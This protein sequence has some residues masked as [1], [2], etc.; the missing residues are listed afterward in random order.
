M[1]DKKGENWNEK[2]LK[3]LIINYPVFGSDYC[4]KSLN[5][6]SISIQKKAQKLGLTYIG[7]NTKYSYDN[8]CLIVKESINFSDVV[9]K[10]NL[11]TGRGN[12]KTVKKY[13]E[14]H[15]IDI[16]HFKFY[17]SHNIGE[18]IPINE[19]LVENSTYTHTSNLKKKLYKLNLKSPICEICDQNDIWNGKQISLILDHINGNNRDN[20]IENLRI[21]CPNCEATLDTH[22]SKNLNNKQNNQT[23]SS[24]IKKNKKTYSC[25]CGTKI[26]NKSKQCQRCYIIERNSKEKPPF[27]QLKTDIEQIGY[28][29]TG[30][31]YSVSDNCIRKWIKKYI[32]SE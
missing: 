22:C 26:S 20:R 32:N 23:V 15:N 5:R 12:R 6:N 19:I 30:R 10:L 17:S 1:I 13:I 18:A 21:V 31:K 9:R 24:I 29:A 8:L 28:N 14:L 25:K 4:S 2:E 7:A 11:P 27:N 16:S 3:Y